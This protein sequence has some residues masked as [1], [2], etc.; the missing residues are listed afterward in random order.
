MTF[1][2]MLGVKDILYGTY[3]VIPSHMGDVAFQGSSSKKLIKVTVPPLLTEYGS[4]E[5]IIKIFVTSQPTSFDLLEPPNIDELTQRIAGYKISHPNTKCIR[6]AIA[7]GAANYH[8]PTPTG[9]QPRGLA[10]RLAKAQTRNLRIVAGAYK[11]TPIRNLETETWVPPLD[12]YLNKR[13]ADFEARPQNPCLHSGQGLDASK[14][15]PGQ[16]VQ[17]ACNRIYRRFQRRRPG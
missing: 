16:L 5:D 4:C 13:L 6:S 17:E 9:G 10:K 2:P 3:K 8:T 7:Y 15:P 12:L 11:A 1:S 14:H